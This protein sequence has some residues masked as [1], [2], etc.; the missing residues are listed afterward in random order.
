MRLRVLRSAGWLGLVVSGLFLS[1]CG[2][3]DTSAL[4]FS[5]DGQSYGKSCHFTGM[6]VNNEPGLTLGQAQEILGTL[7]PGLAGG[8]KNAQACLSNPSSAASGW[9]CEGSYGTAQGT[10]Q[11]SQGGTIAFS[12][13][14]T[15]PEVEGGS[16][17]TFSSVFTSYKGSSDYTFNG[18]FKDSRYTRAPVTGGLPAFTLSLSGTLTVTGLN[19]LEPSTTQEVVFKNVVVDYKDSAYTVSGSVGGQTGIVL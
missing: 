8:A 1:G 11:G 16:T 7:V 18:T 2:S 13:G 12:G 4:C 15:T 6:T 14:L 10:E 19:N 9:T 3:N 17:Y 5:A